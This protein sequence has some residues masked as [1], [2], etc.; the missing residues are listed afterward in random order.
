MCVSLLAQAQQKTT[1]REMME[2]VSG[3]FVLNVPRRLV[4]NADMHTTGGFGIL[5]GMGCQSYC[6]R[7]LT[8]NLTDAPGLITAVKPT[9][10]V[11]G[12]GAS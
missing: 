2:E 10:Q 1:I 3:H 5:A 7:R 12:L 6:G 9:R 4:Q 8:L 11:P